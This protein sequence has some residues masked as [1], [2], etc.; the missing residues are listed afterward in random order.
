VLPGGPGHIAARRAAVVAMAEVLAEFDTAHTGIIHD[1]QIDEFGQCLATAS[2]DGNIRLW[3]VRKPD[4]PAFLAELGGAAG[5][6]HQ[7]AWAPPAV[8]V[9]LA[10][11][12]SDGS[13]AIWGRRASGPKDWGVVAREGLERHG[14]VLALAWAP[15]EHG[16]VLACASEDGT[17]TVLKHSGTIRTGEVQVEHRWQ[18]Q[19]FRAHTGRAVAVSWASPPENSIRTLG[20]SGARVATAGDDGVRVWRYQD[21]LANWEPESID[22]PSAAQAGGSSARDAAWKPW[23]GVTEMLAS[24]SGS[25]VLIWQQSAAEGGS[26]ITDSSWQVTT[27]VE[28]PEDVWKVSWAQV[29]SALVVSYGIKDQR[30]AVLKQN[31]EGGWDVM[32][33]CPDPTK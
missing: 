26:N 1:A 6:V 23:D 14:G 2:A 13:V 20:M 8:G 7:V 4:A 5:P 10:S 28:L 24:A 33:I 21:T 18:R 12:S 25:S 30:S 29:G 16:A 11:A 27:R 17:V 9:L 19:S 31:L 32:N 3:D 15:A 22:F